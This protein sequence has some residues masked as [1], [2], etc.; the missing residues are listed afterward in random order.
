MTWLPRAPTLDGGTGQSPVPNHLNLANPSNLRR[1]RRNGGE[2]ITAEAELPPACSRTAKA[3]PGRP[4]LTVML[5]LANAPLGLTGCGHATVPCPTPTSQ[6][7]RLR[8]ETERLREETERA[9][10]EE[11]AWDA[12]KEAAAQRVQAAQARLDSLAAARRH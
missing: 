3:W 11:E 4:A 10:S 2:E 5:L 6:L 12:R 9:Q 8:G 7:D 1:I